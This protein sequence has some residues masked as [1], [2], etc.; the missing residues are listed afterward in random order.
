MF[1]LVREKFGEVWRAVVPLF[2]VGCALQLVLVPDPAGVLL[3]FA[4]GTALV[5]LGMVLLFAGI[6]IGILP[7]GRFIGA[8][9]PGKGS[10]PLALAVAFVLGLVTTIAEPDVLVLANQVAAL[11]EGELS[12]WWLIGLVSGGV[13]VF[14]A[15]ALLRVL[16]GFSLV[17]LVAGLYALMLVLSLLAP[18]ALV[19]LAYDAGSVTTGVLS[20]PVVLALAAGFISVLAQRSAISDGFGL[21]GLASIGPIIIILLVGLLQ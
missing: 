7:M 16:L 11:S 17:A 6:D 2:G 20:A 18:P 5:V 8:A 15:L 14:V 3:Q 21:L 19:P 1:A 4:A 9:L 10:V 13:G 12:A